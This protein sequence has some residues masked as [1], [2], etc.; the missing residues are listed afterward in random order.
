MSD[1]NV[2]LLD[3]YAE[4]KIPIEKVLDGAKENIKSNLVVIGWDEDDVL[5]LGTSSLTNK[6]VLWL[7]ESAKQIIMGQ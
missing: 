5:Y 6:D 3:E 4:Q 2:I 1:D 7:L